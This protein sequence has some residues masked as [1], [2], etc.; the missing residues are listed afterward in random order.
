MILN[1]TLN[2]LSAYGQEISALREEFSQAMKIDAPMA[3]YS[4]A[5]VGGKADILI[6]TTNANIQKADCSGY[7]FRGYAIYYIGRYAQGPGSFLGL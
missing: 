2:V 6:A 3:K 4:S 7:R 5:R 1:I